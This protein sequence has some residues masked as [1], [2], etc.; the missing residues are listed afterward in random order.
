MKTLDEQI[1]VMTAYKGGAKIESTLRGRTV[2]WHTCTATIIWDWANFDFRV[3]EPVRKPR[4]VRLI[5]HPDGRIASDKTAWWYLHAGHTPS[6]QFEGC[7]PVLFREVL[8]SPEGLI[9]VRFNVEPSGGGGV[10]LHRQHMNIPKGRKLVVG[11]AIDFV[12][13][14]K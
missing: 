12:E 8:P 10:F 6:P 11:E 7:E 4:E 5:M 3:A 14:P 9:Q 13:V 2:E 1:A